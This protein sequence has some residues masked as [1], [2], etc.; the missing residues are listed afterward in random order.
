MLYKE[1]DALDDDITSVVEKAE[2]NMYL[3]DKRL[4]KALDIDVLNY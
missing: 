1:F 3:E 2:L 4:N